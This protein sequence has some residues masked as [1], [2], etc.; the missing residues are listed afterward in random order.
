M[1]DDKYKDLPTFR[2]AIIGDTAVGKTSLIHRIVSNSFSVV[3]EP[4]LDIE[5]YSLIFSLNDQDVKNKTYVML[6]LED[7]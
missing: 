6:T 4:T 7:V 2:I 1:Q 5:K 3:Y